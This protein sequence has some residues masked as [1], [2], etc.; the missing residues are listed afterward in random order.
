MSDIAENL[1]HVKKQVAQATEKAGRSPGAV[2][3]LVVS[4][5]WP[6]E[7]I[8]EAVDAGHTLFGENRVQEAL[9]K[10]PLLPSGLHWHL[11]GHLQKNKI[12]KVL[13]LFDTI[14]SID[15]LE[16]AQQTDR[17][18]GELGRF[19]PVSLLVNVADE[20]SKY[21]FSPS[22]LREQINDLHDLERLQVDGLMAIP[23]FDPDPENTRPSFIALREF[24]DQLQEQ[25]G[26][27]L[28]KLS[29]GMSHDFPVAIEEGATIVRVGSAIF[30][31]RRSKISPP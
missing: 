30:G 1:N 13:P 2:D 19:P 7:I 25:T 22:G 28:P 17:I 3:L 5:T 8:Q 27:P 16:L 6:A 9:A 15:S 21:G 29:M 24:R 4:K 12:R 11:I 23:P 10:I 18:A 14:H 26:V 20:A 31:P